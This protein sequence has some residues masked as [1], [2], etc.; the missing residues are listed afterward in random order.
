MTRSSRLSVAIG[1]SPDWK[2]A[3]G[4]AFPPALPVIVNLESNETVRQVMVVILQRIGERFPPVPSLL[5]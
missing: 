4:R 5:E 3:L 2:S 1:G